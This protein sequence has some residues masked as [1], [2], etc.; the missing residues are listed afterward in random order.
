M[1]QNQY[2]RQNFSIGKQMSAKSGNIQEMENVLGV[3]REEIVRGFF[4]YLIFL[5]YFYC[6]FLLVC[7]LVGFLKIAFKFCR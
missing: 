6:G 5:L 7:M 2:L 1:G 3:E 4:P